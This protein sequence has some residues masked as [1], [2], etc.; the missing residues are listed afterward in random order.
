MPEPRHMPKILELIGED[1]R[2][3]EH[4]IWTKFRRFRIGLGLTQTEFATL[5]QVNESTVAR[6]EKGAG[7]IPKKVL[8]MMQEP[9]VFHVPKTRINLSQLQGLQAKWEKKA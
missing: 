8:R 5:V 4:T 6:W 3:R 1:Y 2:P 7:I 9:I